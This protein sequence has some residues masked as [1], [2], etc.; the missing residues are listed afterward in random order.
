VTTAGMLNAIGLQNEGVDAFI[1]DKIP[2]LSKIG[3]SVVVSIAGKTEQ[4]FKELAAKLNDAPIDAIEVNISCPNIS[5]KLSAASLQQ[6]K[7][8]AQDAKATAQITKTVRSQTKKPVIVKL[9]PNVTDITEIAKAAEGAGASSVS[10]INTIRALAVDIKS[11]RPQ[12]GNVT[13]GLSGPA[14]KPVAL[15]MVWDV[16]KSVNIPVVGIGGIMN[17]ED[18][19]EFMICG[20]SAIQVGTANFVNPTSATDIIAGIR[21]YAKENKIKSIGELVGTLKT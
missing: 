3:T 10:L 14:I 18:A 6:Y 19:L 2:Y 8:F 5:L 21:A 4:E 7:L 16:Y 9:T 11:R 17:T 1:K 13:G 12:L 20:A 15:G